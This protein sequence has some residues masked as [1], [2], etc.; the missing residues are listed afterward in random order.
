VK[1]PTQSAARVFEGH[2][3][4]VTGLALSR[5][6]TLLVSGDDDGQVL[7]WDI[8]T[9]KELKRWKVKGWVYALA[10]SPDSKQVLVSERVPRVFDPGRHDGIRLWDRTTGTPQRDLGPPFKDMY[11]AAAAYA[12]DG[13]L[14][15]LARGGE[16]YGPNGKVFL[17]D[18]ASGKKVREL[19]PGHL[20]GATDLTFH[21]DGKHLATCGR[22]TVVRI[23]NTA[24]GK[25]VKELGK[26]RGGQFKDWFHA[27]SFS[28]DGR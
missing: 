26:P 5:D 19:T 9:G 28:A 7:V 8:A 24:D 13:K 21:P 6:G 14:L 10:L 17:I 20:D 18:P 25:L 23:W 12:P 15:A 11:S 4:W 2:R 16:V 22:D 1:V 27:V 3:E